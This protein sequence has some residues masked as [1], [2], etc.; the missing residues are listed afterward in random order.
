L[1]G[2][3][4]PIGIVEVARCIP[5]VAIRQHCCA[6]GKSTL[7]RETFAGAGELAASASPAAV[8]RVTGTEFA[9][10][11]APVPTAGPKTK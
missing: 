4:L 8:H 2:A 1:L 11:F 7:I 5:R 10:P 3:A 9:Y 6:A